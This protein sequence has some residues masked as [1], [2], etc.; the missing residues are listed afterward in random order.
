MDKEC[1]CQSSC[2]SPASSVA[3]SFQTNSSFSSS[4]SNYSVSS[5]I[6]DE[7]DSFNSHGKQ[8]MDVFYSQQSLF[9]SCYDTICTCSLFAMSNLDY[10]VDESCDYIT[11]AEKLEYQAN[12]SVYLTRR[13]NRR[14]LLVRQFQDLKLNAK[15]KLIPRSTVL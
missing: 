2:S 7:L 8:D 10:T 13:R 12:K 5:N 14:E 1:Q 11:E 15:F 4:A 9:C 6:Q 3:H